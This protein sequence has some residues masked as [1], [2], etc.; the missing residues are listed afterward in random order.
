MPSFLGPREAAATITIWMAAIAILMFVG[1]FISSDFFRFGPSSNVLFF[2]TPIDT[3]AKWAA[4]ATYVAVNQLL[5]TYGLETIT[6]W[7]MN[8]VE[9]RASMDV[10]MP[11]WQ[12]QLVV[13]LWYIY[14][15]VGRV[16]GIQIL[17]MQIDFL[18]VVLAA[19]LATTFLVNRSYLKE[20]KN[21]YRSR[22]IID[23][24]SDFA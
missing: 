13:Q 18:L 17:L 3:W 19:D 1:G 14:M 10:G 22:Y 6:P 11:D 9:N 16:V 15:W 8:T 24:D 4:I 20:K 2:K 23:S 7:M 5:T 21:S 12:A